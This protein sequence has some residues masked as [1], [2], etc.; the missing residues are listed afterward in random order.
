[1]RIK[2][3]FIELNNKNSFHKFTYTEKI[4]DQMLKPSANLKL[5][6][7]KGNYYVRHFITSHV[8]IHGIRLADVN[9]QCADRYIW[10]KALNLIS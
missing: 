10:E 4:W 9:F 7:V 6:I 2:F 8:S 5:C 3:S 1:M